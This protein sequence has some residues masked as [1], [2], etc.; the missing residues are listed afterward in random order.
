M[1]VV[2]KE[3][4]LF[5]VYKNASG[6]DSNT[7]LGALHK[8]SD[9]EVITSQII[10]YNSG[11][12][13]KSIKTIASKLSTAFSL[14][15]NEL[16]IDHLPS[17][18]SEWEY[19]VRY[20][21][22][23][24]IS[25]QEMKASIKTRVKHWN[26][27][28]KPFL[29]FIQLRDIIPLDIIIPQMK[30]VDQRINNSS[31]KINLIG[32]AK[33]TKISESDDINKL[34]APISLSRTEHEYL[35]EIHYNLTKNREKLFECL[36]S[37][38][39]N[40]INHYNFGKLCLSSV[41]M[42]EADNRIENRDFF[43]TSP[44]KKHFCT[45]SSIEGFS[46]LLYVQKN[47]FGH[48][49]NHFKKARE[50]PNHNNYRSNKEYILNLLPKLDIENDN[51]NN[52]IRL[53]NRLDWCLGCLGNRDIAYI[54]ALL[55]MLNPKFT[56]ESLTSCNYIDKNGKKYLEDTETGF[57]FSIEKSRAK[58][59]KSE[60]LDDLSLE[61]INSIIE[62]NVGKERFCNKPIH[63]K[64]FLSTSKKLDSFISP[65]HSS[66]IVWLSGY[67]KEI[68]DNNVCINDL[69][70][71]LNDYGMTRGTITLSRI[72]NTEG[73]L[74]FFRTGSIKAV[75]RKL[76]NSSNVALHHYMPKELIAAYNT[77]QIR[78]FQNLIVVS[79]VSNEDYLLDAVDF[80]TEEE[81]NNFIAI[82]I[83]IV[84][85]CNNPLSSYLK[86]YGADNNCDSPNGELIASISED[87]LTALYTYSE[88]AQ[89]NNIP[90]TALSQ[91]DKNIGVSPLSFIN[92]STHLK[93]ALSSHAD[94]EMRNAHE[95]AINLSKN[96]SDKVN[97][98]ELLL[99]RKAIA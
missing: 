88:C 99:N 90:S 23:L 6:N 81:L 36:H 41:D 85:N 27:Y 11:K 48:F 75:S 8:L 30:S 63:K 35:D 4:Q 98:S 82:M 28:V 72:R 79:A 58:N 96:Y 2:E 56:P 34:L 65:F 39:K 52:E 26:S 32:D 84:G 45:P 51:R 83:E 33:P 73:V 46:N 94:I 1:K 21:Y 42:L 71:S 20:M 77:R 60:Q 49:T 40:I 55:I 17:S 93:T 18:S 44:R 91:I 38:W 78:R 13:P 14:P 64:L 29:D 9:W 66:I 74:E 70:P 86:S 50:L 5:L 76:G 19:F 7:N 57:V 61:I 87:A 97:W 54:S 31:F 53:S 25:S 15:I 10:N 12:T 95:S 92:L 67:K 69:Y 16:D 80:N 59:Y 3:N 37:Y 47:C 89:K 43:I 62:M 24:I 22:G 68:S